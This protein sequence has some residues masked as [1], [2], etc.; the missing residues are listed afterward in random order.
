MT[1]FNNILSF[2]NYYSAGPMEFGIDGPETSDG[3]LYIS[4]YHYLEYLQ[5]N[6]HDYNTFKLGQYLT[7]LSADY[8]VCKYLRQS[9][10]INKFELSLLERELANF[11][12]FKK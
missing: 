1:N 9:F 11:N 3:K 10:R 4:I 5:R 6:P 2:G 12:Q 7:S 8:K